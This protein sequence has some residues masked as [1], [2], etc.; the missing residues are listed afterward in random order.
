MCDNKEI[1]MLQSGTKMVLLSTLILSLAGCGGEVAS[2]PVLSEPS[3]ESI[4]VATPASASDAWMKTYGGDQNDYPFDIQK[5]A[6]G[7]F[8][9]VGGTNL[10][11]GPVMRGNSYLLR[12]DEKGELLWEKVFEKEG[13]QLAKGISSL[14]DGNLLISGVTA[15]ETN[16]MDIFLMQL[17]Q[18]RN[19]IWMKTY[20]GPLDEYCKGSPL[21]DGG[22]IIRGNIV[23]P[24][25][26][27][28]DSEAAGYGGYDGQSNIY[29]SR[30]DEDGNELWTRTYGDGKNIMTTSSIATPEGETVI[31][32]IIFGYPEMDDDV[33]LLKVDGN[34]DTVWSRTW[35]E[36]NQSGYWITPTLDGGYVLTG[37]TM[38][39]GKPDAKGD[40]LLIKIDA[41][42]NETW[43]SVVGDPNKHEVGTQVIETPSGEYVIAGYSMDSLYGTDNDISLAKLDA[44]GRLIRL[45]TIETNNHN[46]LRGI[47][48]H[49]DGGYVITGY[50][51]H[52]NDLDILLVKIDQQGEYQE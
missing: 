24:D 16:G 46:L 39:A 14:E 5:A 21:A 40:F 25:I 12:I 19:E 45:Q 10:R 43:R 37:S 28:A 30:L 13:Y 47:L 50:T 9:I 36:D 33:Y 2:N 42:G 49:P 8:F 51:Q 27:A 18:D 7:G 17:D 4:Q 41:E 48:Q 32:A 31:V 52:G 26:I 44:T 6:D 11:G 23:N 20:G 1:H 3:P 15:S 35:E 38:P 22:Y 34:G 29:I